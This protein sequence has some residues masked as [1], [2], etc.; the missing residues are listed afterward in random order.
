M[1]HIIPLDVIYRV[2]FSNFRLCYKEIVNVSVLKR[3]CPKGR[4][5]L[6]LKKKSILSSQKQNIVDK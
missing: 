6:K 5:C 4:V 2:H 3:T 1:M